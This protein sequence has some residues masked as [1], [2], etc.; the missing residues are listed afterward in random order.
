MQK[1]CQKFIGGLCGMSTRHPR[2][3][4]RALLNT[5]RFMQVSIRT[6]YCLIRMVPEA[7]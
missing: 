5:N 3:A 4:L 6:H 1:H 2:S 7:Q